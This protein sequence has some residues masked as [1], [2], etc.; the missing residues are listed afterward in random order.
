MI[1]LN[2]AMKKYMIKYGHNHIILNIEEITS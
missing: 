1:L 2:D